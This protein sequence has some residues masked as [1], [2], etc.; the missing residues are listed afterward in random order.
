M[1]IEALTPRDE[2]V[3]VL[4][5]RS[6]TNHEIAAQLYISLSTVKTHLASLI[7]KLAARNRLEIAMW[8][9]EAGRVTP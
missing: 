5:A 6:R 9:H 2:E 3:L 1:P 8:A 4:V 7:R